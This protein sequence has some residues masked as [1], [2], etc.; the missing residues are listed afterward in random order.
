LTSSY[1]NLLLFFFLS[2]LCFSFHGNKGILA[3]VDGWIAA[4]WDC[5]TALVVWP[6]LRHAI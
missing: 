3:S 2:V 5:G 4:G 1:N 6:R